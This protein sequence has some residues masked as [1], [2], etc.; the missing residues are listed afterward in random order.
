MG[1]V[2]DALLHDWIREKQ[3]EYIDSHFE[4]SGIVYND[5]IYFEEIDNEQVKKFYITMID[6][7]KHKFKPKDIEEVTGVSLR[8]KKEKKGYKDERII[9]YFVIPLDKVSYIAYDL[10]LEE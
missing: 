10:Y 9:R 3:D 6:G 5:L 2:K 7:S 4:D 8:Y 1:K